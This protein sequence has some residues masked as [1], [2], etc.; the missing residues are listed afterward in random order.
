MDKYFFANQ[1]Y[2]FSFAKP[3]Y[4]R[5]GGTF[6]VR[7]TKRILTFKKRL[8]NANA[9][10]EIE[11]TFLNTPPVQKMDIKNLHHLKGVLV[12]LSNTEMHVDNEKCKSI[13]IGHGTG[14]KKYGGK[15]L[16][17]DT[18][19]Y[20]FV[21]GQKHIQKQIDV[22]LNIP[23]K[24]LIKIG[25]LRFDDYVNGKIDKEKV[26]KHLG[27]KDR[28]RK[29]ILYAPTWK[30]GN[31]T[32]KQY[33]HR[34]CKELS[35]EF[36]LIVRPHHH[37]SRKLP[38]LKFWCKFHGIK[39]V[40]FSNPDKLLKH[41]TMHDF[42]ISDLMISDTSSVMYEYLIT[43]KPIIVAIHKLPKLHNMPD[44]MNVMKHT[45]IYDGS[46]DIV[47][48]VHQSLENSDNEK[49]FGELLNNCFYFNDGKSV[50]RAVRFINSL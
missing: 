50:D 2:Q 1:I 44:N 32:F 8:I 34:F 39:N 14:D 46:Q 38:R 45:P 30:W 5:I 9:F 11:K 36:N 42:A 48:M 41:D 31:G 12:S 6:I 25:N 17:L 18:Y 24:K 37:D 13:F 33:V 26:Y 35:K 15:S 23:E 29:N 21:S 10:P 43:K 7:K 28:S 16:T 4:E 47:K 49:I 27:I 19:D 20:H 40:Y 3:L 22:G